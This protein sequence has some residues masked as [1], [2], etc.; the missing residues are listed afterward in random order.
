MS[1]PFQVWINKKGSFYER[2]DRVEYFLSLAT[3]RQ[4][5]L[6]RNIKSLPFAPQKIQWEV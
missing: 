4:C 6:R 1:S 5:H 2:S 3:T